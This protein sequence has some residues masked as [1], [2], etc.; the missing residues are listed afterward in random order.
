[1]WSLYDFYVQPT[2]KLT[3]KIEINEILSEVLFHTVSNL[4]SLYLHIKI[5]FYIIKCLINTFIY[6]P[7][8]FIKHRSIFLIIFLIIYIFNV[9]NPLVI[10]VRELLQQVLNGCYLLAIFQNH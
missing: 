4:H 5:G 8:I 6:R 9:K 3:T 2:K 7:N 1:M 10:F